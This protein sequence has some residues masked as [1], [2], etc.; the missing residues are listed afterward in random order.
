MNEATKLCF[1]T[2]IFFVHPTC[3]FVKTLYTCQSRCKVTPPHFQRNYNFRIPFKCQ[4][5]TYVASVGSFYF[6]LMGTLKGS[7]P[8]DRSVVRDSGKCA[9]LSDLMYLK[10]SSV[11]TIPQT[12]QGGIFGRGDSQS[13]T[14]VQESNL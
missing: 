4:Q 6:D 8:V 10:T 12:F 2:V 3:L 13:D 1:C 9:S 7:D 14:T 5:N 11:G